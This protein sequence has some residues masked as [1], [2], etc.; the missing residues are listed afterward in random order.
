MTTEV[1]EKSKV[2]WTKEEKELISTY[3]CQLLAENANKEQ[4]GDKNFPTDTMVVS[5]KV[6][7]KLQKDL[8]RGSTANIFDLYYDKFG[9]DSIQSIDYGPGTISP[10]MWGYKS[11]PT[12]KKRSRKP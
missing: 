6:E 12:K 5:Y 8:C 4:L 3:G 7:D 10:T 2:T 11:P 9:K 1:E